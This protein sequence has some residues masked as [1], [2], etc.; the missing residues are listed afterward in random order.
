MLLGI[1]NAKN[2]RTLEFTGIVKSFPTFRR[3]TDEQQSG[4]YFTLIVKGSLNKLLRKQGNS[5]TNTL[6]FNKGLTTFS[7]QNGIKE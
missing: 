3:L 5:S 7:R 2:R 4:S 6:S 1:P